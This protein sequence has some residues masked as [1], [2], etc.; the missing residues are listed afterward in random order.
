MQLREGC[1]ADYC[2]TPTCFTCRKRIAGR[3]PVRPYNPTSART[4]AIYLASQDNPESGLCPTLKPPKG[5]PAA[6]SS[7]VFTPNHKQ[8]VRI[9]MGQN[10]AA[11][12][13]LPKANGKAGPNG[14]AKGEPKDKK[15]GSLR[16]GDA[17]RETE[18][19]GFSITERYESKDYRSFAANMFGTVA[20]KML[21]WLT[22]SGIEDMS[23]IARSFQVEETDQVQTTTPQ[24]PRTVPRSR[25]L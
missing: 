1:G 24:P 13:G 2:R 19:A 22:P 23:R 9:H 5:P 21:E 15:P 3:A 12:G 6:M 16:D 14:V 11:I 17:K 18:T 10:G 20:F 7:L 25:S 8:P 4:L